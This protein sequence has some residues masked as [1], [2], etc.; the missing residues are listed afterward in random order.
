MVALMMGSTP[1]SEG[2]NSPVA[3]TPLP[4]SDIIPSIRNSGVPSYRAPRKKHVGVSKRKARTNARV[5]R[6]NSRK[7][8]W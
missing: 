3:Y 5:R 6:Q 8:G 7:K 1:P 2:I 4:S